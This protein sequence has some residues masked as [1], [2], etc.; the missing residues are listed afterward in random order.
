MF[1]TTTT[2]TSSSSCLCCVERHRNSC[3]PELMMKTS[4]TL[5]S[6]SSTLINFYSHLNSNSNHANVA[7][8]RPIPIL[9]CKSKRKKGTNA[10]LSYCTTN[11]IQPQ[12]PV[13]QFDDDHDHV[14]QNFLMERHLDADFV[15]KASD[16]LWLTFNNYLLLNSQKPTTTAT[17]TTTTTNQTPPPSPPHHHLIDNDSGLL[18]LT[19]AYQW[20]FSID[21]VAAP[22][23][24]KPLPKVFQNDTHQRKRLNLLKYDA[25]AIS[26][27]AGV[28]LSCFYL[29][30]LCYHVDN[31]SR[32]SVPRVFMQ[33]KSKK[34]G[35]RSEDVRNLLEKVVSGS[36]FALSSPRLMIPAAIYGFWGLSNHFSDNLLGFQLVPAMFG[37]FAY[38]AAA[39]VQ[40]YRDNEDLL[41]VFPESWEGS[42]N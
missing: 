30:L 17:T 28:V 1:Y 38:K 12:P 23:N 37:M 42:S 4:A 40:V 39:L 8:V 2:S 21:K 31:L 27:A 24:N 29:Q 13:T 41:I 5:I 14:L 15:S 25:V 6:S 32:E 26:Y 7:A 9:L 34:I 36:A 33:K 16:L 20:I 10:R 3:W 22:L 19:K 35:I 18:K 11:P